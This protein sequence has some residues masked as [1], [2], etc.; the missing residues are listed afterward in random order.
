MWISTTNDVT[1][2]QSVADFR[3]IAEPTR[4]DDRP[5]QRIAV[6]F[7]YATFKEEFMRTI[8]KPIVLN[9][10]NNKSDKS[11]VQKGLICVY[12]SQKS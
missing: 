6:G 11:L 10:C 9:V 1:R 12:Y 4:F 7:N 5:I 2:G 3:K 8:L